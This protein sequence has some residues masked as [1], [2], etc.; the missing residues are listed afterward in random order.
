MTDLEQ[1]PD[2]LVQCSICSEYELAPVDCD[3]CADCAVL[4]TRIRAREEAYGGRVLV[5]GGD[6]RLYSADLLATANGQMAYLA[7][8]RRVS[9][10]SREPVAHLG[11]A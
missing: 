8:L 5:V 11:E 4:V 6:V 9:C 10:R 3:I 2:A 7:D 1:C